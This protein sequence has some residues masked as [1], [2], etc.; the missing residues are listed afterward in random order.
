MGS[1]LFSFKNIFKISPVVIDMITIFGY[2]YFF[3]EHQCYP[4]FIKSQY[5]EKNAKFFGENIL[6]II[7]LVPGSKQLGRYPGVDDEPSQ[8]PSPGNPDHLATLWIQLLC[9]KYNICMYVCM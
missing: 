8:G 3:L 1:N 6:K 5:F 9:C 4:F 2:F 7:T